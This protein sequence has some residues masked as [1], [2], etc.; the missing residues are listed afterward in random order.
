MSSAA[1]KH[2]SDK[3]YRPELLSFAALEEVSKVLVHG[4]AKY[5]DHNWR[6]G[7]KWSRLL[8]AALRHLFAWARG[9]NSDFESGFSHLAHAMCC[10]MFLL[11]HQL[12]NLGEDDRC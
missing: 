3:P 6:K 10:V 12:N 8:G 9:E 2:D 11:E 7:F 5:G 1:T 4:A